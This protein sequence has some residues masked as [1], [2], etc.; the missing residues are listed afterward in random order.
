VRIFYATSFGE[1]GA[2]GFSRPFS[3][4]IAPF[5]PV[6]VPPTSEGEDL[7]TNPLVVP[8]WHSSMDN[9]LP[10]V[11]CS[12]LLNGHQHCFPS[13]S[14]QQREDSSHS[15]AVVPTQLSIAATKNV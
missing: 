2:K 10:S 14:S 6:A 9:V 11:P 4:G 15:A 8:P 3:L 1:S 5:F 13:V 12:Y 7:K